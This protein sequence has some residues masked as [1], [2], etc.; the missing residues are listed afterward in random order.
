M[1]RLL[2][3]PLRGC[4]KNLAPSQPLSMQYIGHFWWRG[5]AVSAL[6]KLRFILNSTLELGIMR[7]RARRQS[8][9]KDPSDISLA[10]V[11]RGNS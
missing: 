11:V 2:P 3:W 9:R 5:V 7:Y 8:K 6:E 4:L 1:L 10:L